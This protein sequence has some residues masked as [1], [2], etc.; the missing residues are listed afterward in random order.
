MLNLLIALIG[1][2]FANITAH[3]VEFSYKEKAIMVADMQDTFKQILIAKPNHNERLFVARAIHS[4]EINDEENVDKIEEVMNEI[5]TVRDQNKD[6]KNHFDKK[7]EL[8][9][10]AL[11]AK[12]QNMEAD[13]AS[14]K[15]YLKKTVEEETTKH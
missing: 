10:F 11:S 3:D 12:M 5:K 7:F 8:L 13:S 15:E 9:A 1:A 14:L 4:D 6:L 2:T